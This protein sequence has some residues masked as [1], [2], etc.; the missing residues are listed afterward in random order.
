M[1]ILFDETIEFKINSE[2]HICIYIE[3][4]EIVYGCETLQQA[5]EVFD[6][7]LTSLKNKEDINN[8]N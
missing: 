6:S 5:I 3:N 2:G 7:S 4:E 8:G 1:E